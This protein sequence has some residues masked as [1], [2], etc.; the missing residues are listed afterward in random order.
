MAKV[1]RAQL[2]LIAIP[3]AMISPGSSSIST[4]DSTGAGYSHNQWLS[5]TGEELQSEVDAAFLGT[6][7]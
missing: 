4:M 7:T 5:I 1:A 3:L 2:S 6:S